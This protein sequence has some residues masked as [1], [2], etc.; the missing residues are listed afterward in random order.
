MGVNHLERRQ[1]RINVSPV[2]AREDIPP[3]DLEN[4]QGKIGEISP[5]VRKRRLWRQTYRIFQRV[6]VPLPSLCGIQLQSGQKRFTSGGTKNPRNHENNNPRISMSRKSHKLKNLL[7]GNE[8]K[9]KRF[10]VLEFLHLSA[11]VSPSR[12][13]S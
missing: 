7:W 2:V 13:A 6:R 11:R 10:G 9:E 5:S 4:A 3:L 12:S 1:A 8:A